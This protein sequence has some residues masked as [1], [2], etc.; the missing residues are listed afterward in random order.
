M[1]RY[2]LLLLYSARLQHRARRRRRGVW[3]LRAKTGA[4]PL[5]SFRLEICRDRAKT[6][7]GAR[8]KNN[9]A[10]NDD[11]GQTMGKTNVSRGAYNY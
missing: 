6:Y 3:Y 2:T 9:N 7:R 11:D 5:I 10:E 1:C 8:E 4:G